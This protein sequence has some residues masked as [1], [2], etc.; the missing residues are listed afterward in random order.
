MTKIKAF[1]RYWW[2]SMT[3]SKDVFDKIMWVLTAAAFI[4]V[5][6]I[7]AAGIALP[8]RWQALSDPQLEKIA[9]DITVFLGLRAIFWLPF[10]RHERQLAAFSEQS[11]AHDNAQAA[12][13]ARLESARQDE[14]KN[15]KTVVGE[16]QKQID[17]RTKRKKIKDSL[18]SWRMTMQNLSGQLNGIG[19]YEYS[20][21]TRQRFET[22]YLEVENAVYNYLKDNVGMSE[23]VSF[24]DVERIPKVELGSN[25]HLDIP[26]FRNRYIARQFMLNRLKFRAEQLEKAEEKLDSKDFVLAFENNL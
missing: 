24:V 20:D 12:S 8:K 6:L 13:L 26:S 16:L 21:E 17:D 5:P 2:E 23:A 3:E 9:W 11:S 14:I 18:G 19:Y 1:C 22:D 4:S 15:L 25:V 7:E 10:R